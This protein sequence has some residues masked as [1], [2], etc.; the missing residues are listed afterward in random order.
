MKRTTTI[1]LSLLAVLCALGSCKKFLST[2]PTSF[3]PPA[4]YYK[5]ANLTNAL[6]G[7]YNPL[8]QT[9][10]YGSAMFYQLGACTDE[11][12]YGGAGRVLTSGVQVYSF[13]YTNADVNAFWN[14][15]Y[16]GIERANELIVH[17]DPADTSVG[18]QAIYGEALFLR[19]YYH[20]LLV[21]NFGDVPLKTVAANSLDSL[22]VPRSP[23]AK[24]YEQIVNDMT[25]AEKKVLTADKIGNSSRIS[26]TTV[27]GILARVCLYMAGN[28]INDKTQYANALAWATKVQQSGLHSLNPSFNQVFINEA[29]DVYD[30]KEQ[31]WEVDFSGNNTTTQ[32]TGGWV[33]SANGIPF[34]ATNTYSSGSSASDFIYSDTGYSYGFVWATG[35]LYNLYDVTDPRRD[36]AIQ[37]FNYT[38]T[39]TTAP[40]LVTRTALTGPFAY[41][42]TSAKWRRNYE[43]IYPKNKNFTP[44]NFPLLRYADVLLMLAEAE[45]NVNGSTATAVNAINQV[46]ER[47]YTVNGNTAPVSSITLLTPGSGYTT[48]PLVGSTNQGS[49]LAYSTT[50]TNGSIATVALVSGGSG[51]T[52][53]P[54]VYIGNAWQPKIPYALN[55]QVVNN[56]NLYT[57]TKAGISTGVGP[58]QASGASDPNVTGAT[59]T[60]A[61]VAATASTTLLSKADVDLTSVT[62]TDIQNERARELCFE[63]LR[64]P[65]LIR[66]GIFIPTM[67]AVAQDIN[68]TATVT[69]NTKTQ[70][71]L[72]YNNVSER[73]L[74]F[75][76]P[77]SEMTVNKQITNNNPGW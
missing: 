33:G 75:P 61:G 13:D 22:S 52:T 2:E 39:T 24:V 3:L 9:S 71:A 21:N 19:A 15:L 44:E 55:A 6:A 57:V 7:V 51:F 49:G 69:T 4:Q 48:A 47:G 65:D 41:N 59:F 53:A 73:N 58:T 29:S 72:G 38:V 70:A 67:K 40:P 66:W 54:L 76:I 25:T 1:Y 46:R 56:G 68:N 10:V 43:K 35:K 60:Y 34:T 8:F 62:M 45:L 32:Q 64:R 42:R 14:T 26:K 37:S 12:F 36:W 63:S 74:L 23:A 20:F 11:S 28:P 30:I 18:T 17:L 5:G 31:M 16:T 27:E 50:I 77:S